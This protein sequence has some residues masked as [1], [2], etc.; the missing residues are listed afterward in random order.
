M[1]FLMSVFQLLSFSCLLIVALNADE[2]TIHNLTNEDFFMAV[3]YTDEKIAERGGP[4]VECLKQSSI[5]VDR[6][7]WQF[8]QTRELVYAYKQSELKDNFDEIGWQGV[9]KKNIS[10]LEGTEFYLFKENGL[11]YMYNSL[12]WSIQE[13]LLQC[14]GEISDLL[15]APVQSL[16][17]IDLPAIDLNPYKTTQAVIRVGNELHSGEQEFLQK[18][19][20]R[21]QAALEKMLGKSL[22]GKYIP[23]IALVGSGGGYRAMFCTT[24]SLVG[25]DKIGLLD[26]TSYITALSGSTWAVSS[27]FATGLPIKQFR[28][29]LI[30]KARRGL[31]AISVSEMALIGE[32]LRTKLAFEQPLS[33]VDIYGLLLGT[34]LLDDFQDARHRVYLSHQIERVADGSWPYPI[35]TAVRAEP[36]ALSEWYEFT[37]H[38]IGASWLQK[39]TPTWAFG[40]WFVDGHSV[41]YA[42]EQSLGYLMGIWGSAF[43]ANVKQIYESIQ[44]KIHFSLTHEIIEKILLKEVGDDRITCG[45]VYNFVLGM[46]KPITQ[47]TILEMVDAGA[48]PG[49]NLPYPPISG[50]RPERQADII[51]FL[52]SSA[53]VKNGEVLREVEQYARDHDLPFPKI[54]YKG[55]ENRA[56]SIFKDECDPEVPVVIYMPRINDRKFQCALQKPEYAQ[57]ASYLRDFN[58]EYCVEQDCCNTMNFEYTFDQA[59]RVTK[60][61]EFNMIMCQDAIENAIRWVINKR[62]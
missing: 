62:S 42:P 7:T 21:V 11:L 1:R 28:Q 59:M 57:Y 4:V 43:G 54:R 55:I 20:P 14:L 50:E 24:G 3:Y 18:R 33:W 47:Q 19:K 22:D 45:E 60:L 34:V 27:W 35:Y 44:D 37:P 49:F 16:V 46:R 2:I 36:N 41:D 38:E 15:I 29:L 58:V 26:A 39:Y 32:A 31:H 12:Q 52:D 56:I 51:I 5:Q 23:K 9:M 13:P 17:S 10:E 30:E 25:A 40:R 48:H 53:S 6:P 61:T 8:W